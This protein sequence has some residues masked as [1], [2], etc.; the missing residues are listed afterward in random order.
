MHGLHCSHYYSYTSDS[1]ESLS[2]IEHK[3]A[4]EARSHA[5]TTCAFVLVG[6]RADLRSSRPDS[7]L[8]SRET[9]LKVAA[10][11]GIR[12]ER[13]LRCRPD[14]LVNFGKSRKSVKSWDAPY[15]ECSAKTDE[16]VAEL[17][18]AAAAVR[19]PKLDAGVDPKLYEYI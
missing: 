12:N 15:L 8:V 1:P 5:G 16:G 11:E 7:E 4:P 9:A 17:L 19:F 14:K 2:L 13:T 18:E 6:L 3:Y 10:S